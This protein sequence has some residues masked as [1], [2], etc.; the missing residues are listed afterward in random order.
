M[1]V[2]MNYG[3]DRLARVFFGCSPDEVKKTVFLTLG[4]PWLFKKISR[5]KFVVKR[6]RGWWDLAVIKCDDSYA[7]VIAAGCGSSGVT[8]IVRLLTKFSCENIVGVGLAGALKKEVQIGDIIVPAQAIP[9]F[10]KNMNEAIKH[11]EELYFIYRNLLKD[12]CMKNGVYLHEGT[13]CTIDAITSED[14]KF[15]AY[16]ERMN[17][18]GVDMETFHLYREA[19]KAGL[20]ISSFHVV[21]DNPIQHKSFVD[22][23]PES[24]I[25]RKNKIYG[26][27]PMLIRSIAA[28]V[29]I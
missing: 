2:I 16:A 10:A 21:S 25:A 24:D 14:S 19:Q 29:S 18:L 5:R 26:K 12:F 23:I 17:L 13:I 9:A 1:S 28:S 22:D 6:S 8:N 4:I 11:S 20:K 7:T 15:Y 3:S 27:T